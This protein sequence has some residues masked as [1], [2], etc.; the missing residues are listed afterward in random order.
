MHQARRALRLPPFSTLILS[1]AFLALAT[2]AFAALARV[3][4]VPVRRQPADI[5]RPLP[6]VPDLRGAPGA[7]VLDARLRN[8]ATSTV[9]QRQIQSDR[10]QDVVSVILKGS[11]ASSALRAIGAEVGTEVGGYRT[12][13]IPVSAL[14]AFL[15][16]PGLED[17]SLGYRL[18]PTLDVSI[19]D[20]GV[21]VKRTS[22]PP[23]Y[24][25]NGKN[26]IVG[27]VDT[28]MDYQ[29]DD[30][31][32]PDNSTRF[33]YLWDQNVVGSPPAGFGYGNE[34][35]QAQLNA[36]TCTEIDD[37]GHG[38]HVSGIAVGDGS[39]T[40]NFEPGFTYVGVA[41]A[42]NIIG[43]ATNF[44]IA[45]VIDAVNY[46]FTKATAL[47]RPAVV[48][49]SLGTVLGPHDG[50]TTFEQ[51]L[52]ALTG[53]GKIIVTSAGNS[54]ADS[55]HASGNL[56][57]SSVHS[58]TFSVPSYG[59][60][61]GA[62]NDYIALDFWHD[63]AN[64]YTIR[65]KRPSSGTLVGPVTKGNS[66]VSNT[67]DGQIIIDYTNTVDPGNGMTEL[68]VEVNDLAGTAP[69]AGVWRVDVTSGAS[70]PGDQK[71][72]SWMDAFLGRNGFVPKFTTGLVD[73]TVNVG[74]PG[75]A[76][77]VITAAAH[78]T[79]DT[80]PSI[81]GNIYSFIGAVDP[82][83]IATFSA[84]GPRRDGV[85][86]PDISA[87]GSAISSVLSGDSFPPW[88]DPL[89]TPDGMHLVLQGTSM[90]APHVD[91]RGGPPAAE[92][93]D[94]DAPGAKLLLAAGARFRRHHG[95]GAEPA[96][97]RRPPRPHDAPVQRHGSARGQRSVPHA[98]RPRSTA[99]PRSACRGR[100]RTP[101]A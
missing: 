62:N 3:A 55:V 28:G 65:V 2:D 58:Y 42:A 101:W 20:I 77:S 10:G 60:N 69:R 89:I 86:K 71:I 97:G 50:T 90:A 4:E 99:A 93:S 6:V 13:R 79:K 30:F 43:V 80:W 29:H 35:T 67:T 49:L 87:P 34:C 27:I 22:E 23:L 25:W 81:D 70:V 83:Q 92:I 61:A 53:P 17:V 100:R 74:S 21:G 63:P 91:R 8:L 72:H 85:A 47:G 78:V 36:G 33:L 1:V 16:L 75:T 48:N 64:W 54:Q 52:D 95:R 7:S 24:G 45:G 46:V 57:P 5:D 38:S 9:A 84:R 76:D 94:A 41:N 18:R 19:P 68:Y 51:M 40:G 59:A 96:L 44:S 73:S 98:G 26:V 66:L 11:V 32:N 37:N 56:L 15:K 39:A 88:P 31:R 14:P 82:P 12:V